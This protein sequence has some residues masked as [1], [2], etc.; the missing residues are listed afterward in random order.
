MT[1]TLDAPGATIAYDVREP[2][3]SSSAAPL[4]LIGSPMDASGFGT[5][6]GHFTD[7]R[8]IT[9]DPRGTGRST[10]TDPAPESTPEQHA[11]DVRRVL[12]AVGGGPV[13]LFASSGGAVNALALVAAHPGLLRTLVAH[14]PP[15]ARLIPDSTDAEAA[16]LGI[17]ALYERF[18]LGPAMVKF[19]GIVSLQGPVPP[20]FADEPGPDP[21]TFGLPGTDDGTRDDV[22]LGQNL[23][24]C[25]LFEPDFPALKATATRIV[26]GVGAESEGELAHRA[27]RAVAANL[28]VEPVVFPSNH[29]GFLGGEFGQHGDPVP[30][31]AKLREVL[32]ADHGD[33]AVR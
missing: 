29:A 5:L 3:E 33:G 18:G 16:V 21:A 4:M 10:R 24:T 12:E 1:H 2:A 22:L 13:D 15:A 9:Y 25:C 17:R 8:V 6:A 14:E 19:I 32:T 27:G 26:V 20:G 28:G 11:D 31:A 7:R 30:F 23:V